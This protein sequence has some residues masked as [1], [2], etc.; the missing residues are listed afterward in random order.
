M[1]QKILTFNNFV[2]KTNYLKIATVFS[3]KP[4]ELIVIK[5]NL[6]KLGNCDW[7]TFTN[8]KIEQNFKDFSFCYKVYFK[9]AMVPLNKINL[10]LA[11]SE[12]KEFEERKALSEGK[13]S[14][15]P[16]VYGE[17]KKSFTMTIG[18]CMIIYPP[19]YKLVRYLTR[20]KGYFSF[21][22]NLLQNIEKYI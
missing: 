21:D 2:K 16:Y 19:L 4:F 22:Y 8:G 9:H 1:K 11:E 6:S 3:F 18:Y 13:R 12:F 15:Y 17:E 14:K 5:N 20:S 7:I 10:F